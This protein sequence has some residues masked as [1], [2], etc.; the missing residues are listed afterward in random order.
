MQI[1]LFNLAEMEDESVVLSFEEDLTN[2]DF[3]FL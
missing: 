1:S 2:L 3:T